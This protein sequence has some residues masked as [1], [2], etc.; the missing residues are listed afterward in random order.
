MTAAHLQP[1]PLLAARPRPGPQH[2]GAAKLGPHA[3]AL[4]KAPGEGERGPQIHHDAFLRAL[5]PA[6]GR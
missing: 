6:V 3:V 1:T 5:R 2:W 4:E